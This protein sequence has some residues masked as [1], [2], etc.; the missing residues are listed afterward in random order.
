MLFSGQADARAGNC[1]RSGEAGYGCSTRTKDQYSVAV[2]TVS[3]LFVGKNA[4]IAIS[5]MTL[6]GD[7]RQILD[8]RTENKPMRYDRRVQPDRRLNNI[9]VEEVPAEV[10]IRHPIL[11]IQFCRLGYR[12][13]VKS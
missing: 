10:F 4:F 3:V 2:P 5:Q 7:K 9:V 1:L 12:G 11:W 6:T 8:R 13:R